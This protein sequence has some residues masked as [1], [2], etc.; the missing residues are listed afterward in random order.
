MWYRDRAELDSI[1]KTGV[2]TYF[3]EAGNPV[4]RLNA[5]FWL[6]CERNDTAFT[7]PAMATGN[8]EAWNAVAISRELSNPEAQF[9]DVGAN[10]GY[11][12]LMAASANVPTLIF[13]PNPELVEFITRSLDINRIR[14]DWF[15]IDKGVS[16]KKG[17]LKLY[18]HEN[19]SGANSFC[20]TGD[21]FVEVDVTTLD[22]EVVVHDFVKYVI[23]VDVEGFEREVWNGAKEVRGSL[24]NI[25]FVE[26]V[27]A[28]HGKEYNAEWLDEVLET[29]DLLMVN[30]D[31][32]LRPVGRDE[33][34]N[35]EFETI[36][37]NKRQ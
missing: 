27:P 2:L 18:R 29:H 25:W 16:Y 35:V 10:V 21:D 12:S 7:I 32:T 33:A 37:F 14:H 4:V 9:I 6:E 5:S 28:R 1:S 34:L 31:G 26:W 17:K 11:Y 3:N 20:G 30:Y 36:V 8:W 13:E 19:H 24:N 15:I 22:K 23:K